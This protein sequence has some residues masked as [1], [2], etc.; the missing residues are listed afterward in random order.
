VILSVLADLLSYIRLME[1]CWQQDPEKRPGFDGIA[2]RLMAMLR[3]RL[4]A[5]SLKQYGVSVL[6][7]VAQDEDD[8]HEVRPSIMLRSGITMVSTFAWSQFHRASIVWRM[9][10][11]QPCLSNGAGRLCNS[12][13]S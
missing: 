13:S 1:E 9:L 8:E 12:M 2:A 5:S 3:W 10:Q 7:G 4:L 11:L 6:L